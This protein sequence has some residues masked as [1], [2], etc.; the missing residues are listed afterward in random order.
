MLFRSKEGLS[1]VLGE[2]FEF[3][4]TTLDRI[5]MAEA[6]DAIGASASAGSDFTVQTLTQDFDRG[7]QLL[8]DNELNPAFPQEALDI[9]KNQTARVVE[10][11]LKSPGYLMQ[12]ALRESLFPASDPS[13]R[14]A[15][16]A[17]VR[18]LT[19]NDIVNYYKA[20]FRD[21]KSTRLNSSHT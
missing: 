3:G 14:D 11:Q 20:A 15:T 1:Q 18:S 10:A 16:P 9:V 2:L 5:A 4:S 12:R 21:R 8:A 19:R 6:L 13:L 17:S 7:V